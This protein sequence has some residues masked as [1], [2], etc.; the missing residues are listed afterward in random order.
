MVSPYLILVL[1]LVGAGC[2]TLGFL[3]GYAARG[4]QEVEEE[5][6]HEP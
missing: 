1:T 5:D 2:F 6:D 4:A 3:F